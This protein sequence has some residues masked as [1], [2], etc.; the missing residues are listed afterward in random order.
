MTGQENQEFSNLMQA[1]F[2][3]LEK[4]GTLSGVTDIQ[5]EQAKVARNFAGLTF[6]AIALYP[7]VSDADN[8]RSDLVAIWETV[9]PLVLAIG[10]NLAHHFNDVDVAL[11]TDQ[12][13]GALEGNATHACDQAAERAREALAEDAPV[14]PLCSEHSTLNRVQQGV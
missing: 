7:S 2:A 13:R 9:D 4:A 8:V 14:A 11:F 1:A 6:S 3:I 12:V 10:Q 5:R